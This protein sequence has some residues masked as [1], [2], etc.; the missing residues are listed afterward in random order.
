MDA[1]TGLAIDNWN[2][3]ANS[4][5][6]TNAVGA[7]AVVGNIVYAGGNFR[8][9][10]GQPRNYV[11]ALDVTT[12][13]ATDWNPGAS[14]TVYAIAV[15][16]S[17]VYVGGAFENFGNKPL[18]RIAALGADGTLSSWDPNAVDGTVNA[19]AVAGGTVYVGR[20]FNTIGVGGTSR[21]YL[22]ALDAGTGAATSWMPN[23]N[24][25]V[26]ALAAAG[27]ALYVGRQ[28]TQ[29]EGQSRLG[30][31]AF[32]ISGGTVPVTFGSIEAF[33]KN[34][35]L[36]VNWT[37]LKETNNHH[38]EIEASADGVHFQTI[39]EPV[40]SKAK[41]GN[42]DIPVSYSFSYQAG[43]G[44]MAIGLLGF[45]V[46][47]LSGNRRRSGWQLIMIIVLSIGY[48]SCNKS[49][50]DAIDISGKK[51]FIRIA[52]VD[53]DGTKTYIKTVQVVDGR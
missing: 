43:A 6:S 21:R 48:I 32:D 10:G 38:Y 41:D 46:M 16:G 15:D 34:G 49:T 27:G 14:T 28:F 44:L 2:P 39:G 33:M 29:I 26:L 12:G 40:L 47:L 37:A 11:A 9:I 50:F 30:F 13:L 5:L 52:Q 19:L 24:I 1:S 42:A 22:A 36:T 35:L 25:S 17:M 53:I 51:L 7:L 4:S 23:P 3:N 31:A 20:G 8:N 45:A 18:N